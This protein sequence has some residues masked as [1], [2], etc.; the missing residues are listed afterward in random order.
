MAEQRPELSALREAIQ[1]L[2]NAVED[3]PQLLDNA[4]VIWEAVSFAEDGEPQRCIRYAVPTD[5]FTISGTLGLLEAG[6][7]YL[8][9]DGLGES[10]D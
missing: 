5:N 2:A 9:R 1:N 4:L 8:R 6:K 3:E 7:F 10:D